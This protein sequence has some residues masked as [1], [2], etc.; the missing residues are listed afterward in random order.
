MKLEQR[1]RESV[2]PRR[3]LSGWIGWLALRPLASLFGVGVGA[4]NLAYRVGL[5]PVKH[6]PLPVVSVGNLTVGGTGKTPIT[7]WLAQALAGRGQRPAILLRGYGGR[8][9]GVSVVSHGDGVETTVEAV[10][11]EAFMLARRFGGVVLTAR[12]RIDGAK[13][14]AELGCN[15][16]LL[17][18]GFQHRALARHFDIVLVNQVRGPLLPAGPNRERPSALR[19]ADAIVLVQQGDEAASPKLPRSAANKPIFRARFVPRA[20]VTPDGGE[21]RELSLA[22]LTGRR[23]AA[24]AGIG[25][26][27]RFYSL[28][29]QWEAQ[30]EEIVEYP[31]HHAY[32]RGDW[33]EIA[34]R[35]RNVDLVVTTEKDL[36]K[37]EAFPFAR[38]KLVALRIAAEIERGDELLQMI[39]TRTGLSTA[40]DGGTDGDQ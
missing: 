27:D 11:D 7:L 33:Q 13:R 14:A 18:D 26:P 10:G 31:D 34:R 25:S 5:M 35:T 17:D 37:L 4:R 38:G 36:V 39:L 30:L 40:A 15:V 6:A 2:W 8:A 20:L 9:G 12:R 22:E 1:V 24:V 23:V 32:T 3:G 29:H 21:W 19:R 16:L 28:V